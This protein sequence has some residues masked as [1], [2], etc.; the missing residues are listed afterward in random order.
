MS[1]KSRAP[2]G[3]GAGPIVTVVIL[4]V[5]AIAAVAYWRLHGSQAAVTPA[6][7]PHK[8]LAVGD[9]APAFDVRTSTGDVK[10][11]DLQGKAWLVEVFAVWCPHC[12]NEAPTLTEIA[13]KYADKLVVVG[14]LGSPY[15][16]DGN[17][18]VTEGD[19]T[20]FASVFG[21]G[22]PLGFDVTGATPSPYMRD[23]FP[24]L[25]LVAPDGKV[26]WVDSGEVDRSALDKQIDAVVK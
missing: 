7:A 25:T 16:F 15:G 11:S 19:V 26:A 17:S 8:L 4:A 3:K 21:A 5:L 10:S 20:K 12:Q 2:R 6:T 14:I 13:K 18:P 1:R 9:L 23:G 24:S 22:Y